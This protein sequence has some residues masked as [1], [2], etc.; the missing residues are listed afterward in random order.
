MADHPFPAQT[1]TQPTKVRERLGHDLRDK[2]KRGSHAAWT[3]APGPRDPIAILIEQG[4]S[5]LPELLPKRYARMA[6]SP[7]AFLRGSAAVMAA[8]LAA[9]PSTG[10]LV[11]AAGDCHCMNFGGFATPEQRKS[12]DINDFDETAVA[13]WEWDLKRLATSFVVATLHNFDKETRRDLART[14]ARGYREEMTRIAGARVLDSWYWGLTLDNDKD[15]EA[16]GLVNAVADKPDDKPKHR[17]TLISVDVDNDKLTDK[18]PDL[19]HPPASELPAFLSEVEKM[20]SQY[21][22]SLIPERRVLLERFRFADAAYKVVGVGSVGTL[23]GVA[24]M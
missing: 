20:L 18:P 2:C 8:D 24:L 6:E 13:P 4:K 9:A 14:V 3:P 15:V 23:C 10:L 17:Q 12:F 11:Q 16:I 7:F 5:R 22:E 1:H 19:Y 21:E